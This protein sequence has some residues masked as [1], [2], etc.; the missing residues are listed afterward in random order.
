MVKTEQ[1]RM[2]QAWFHIVT[3]AAVLFMQIGQHRLICSL[4]MMK[5]IA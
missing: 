3:I 2:F 1:G 5:L 4:D